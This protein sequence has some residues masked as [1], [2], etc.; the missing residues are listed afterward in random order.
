MNAIASRSKTA[1]IGGEQESGFEQAFS[2]LAY[3]YIKDKAPRL[4]EFVVGFQLVDRNEDNTKAVGVFG[5]KLGE[6][7]LY[8]PVFFLNGDLKGHEL[9]YI[10]DQDTFVPMKEN[11]VNYI[12]SKRPHALGERSP[13]DV[14]Q[15]GGLAPNIEQLTWPPEQSKFGSDQVR[16]PVLDKEEIAAF[17]PVLSAGATKR[18]S[19]LYRGDGKGRL[20]MDKVAADPWKAA[21]AGLDLDLP[22]LLRTNV[23][24]AKRAFQLTRTHPGIKQAMDKFYGKDFFQKMAFDFR[25]ELLRERKNIMPRPQVKKAAAG[26]VSLSLLPEEKVA[27]GPP[28]KVIVR[29]EVAMVQNLP[30]L[31]EEQRSK[32]LNDGVLIVDPREGEE[33]SVAYNTQASPQR[34]CNPHETTIY[35]VLERPGE[36]KEMLVISNPYSNK[37]QHNYVTVVRMEDGNKA[38]LNADRGV[39]WTRQADSRD[40]YQTWFDDLPES[41][42][43]S[44]DSM[45]VAVNERGQGTVPFTVRKVLGEGSYIV[46]F[47]SHADHGFRGPGHR[48]GHDKT[49]IDHD[50][51]YVSPYGAKLCVNMSQDAELRAY[52]EMLHVPDTF[53]F[54]QLRQP[55]KP[56]KKEEGCCNIMSVSGYDPETTSDPAPIQPGDM[57]DIQMMFMQK[58]SSVKIISDGH[59]FTVQT[60]KRGNERGNLFQTLRTLVEG[61]GLREKQARDM[62]TK[63]GPRGSASFRV[64]YAQGPFSETTGPGPTSPAF[65]GPEYGS[66]AGRVHPGRGP[67][68]GPDRSQYLRS[69]PHAGSERRGPGSAGRS[70]R[71][72]GSLRRDHA[73]GHAQDRAAGQ[74]GRPLPGRP[75]EGAGQVGSDAVPL[76]LA[77]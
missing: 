70:G 65:P 15:L 69:L 27:A 56:K 28:A 61:H 42:D 77:R 68:V 24:L 60:E 41:S 74:L 36:W 72:Q 64:K 57:R 25:D 46:D 13:K 63:A 9:L 23:H 11:W 2:S 49:W 47:N 75:D 22:G 32:L 40:K 55:P 38:W 62:I 51:D 71:P 76:L 67:A 14:F 1:N 20:N 5:F 3:A 30:D 35:D 4:I 29:D 6:R 66:S 7:W 50:G 31:D 52:S 10:K 12:M 21:L 33:V 44:K 37:G 8:A 48:F 16:I 54:L 17:L 43:L 45:Y 34:L 58:T 73:F 19:F 53:K 26:P 39:V 59:E 18:A